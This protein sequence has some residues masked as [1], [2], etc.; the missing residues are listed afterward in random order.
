MIPFNLFGIR[1]NVEPWFWLTGFLLGR[2]FS[3]N[4]RQDFIDVGLWMLV[5]FVSIL[6]HEL[7]HALTGRRLAGGENWIRLW[8]FGGLAYNQ[9]G[10]FTKKTRL[11]MILAGPG[12]G[13]ALFGLTVA[14][15]FILHPGVAGLHIL[16]FF[17]RGNHAVAV[18]P[19]AYA[20][21]TSGSPIVTILQN[22]IW[23]NFWWSL[24]NLLPVHPLDGG[25]AAG[26]L[27]KS[28]KKVHTIG[29]Y[30]GL[31]IA[32]LGGL[33]LKSIFIAILF[34]FLAYSNFKAL[35]DNPD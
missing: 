7:G 20:F 10:R 1:V 19:E 12:T 17:V 27:I 4:D 25:Q 13:F 6:V 32:I 8:A 3:I 18:N 29:L 26:E 5:V 15:I 31:A 22:L 23:V 11:A 9:G 21:L 35:R 30:T 16:D 33:A 24:A 28:R 14:A 2:G 34:G